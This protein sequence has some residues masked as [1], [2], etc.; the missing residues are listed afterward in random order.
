MATTF[1]IHGTRLGKQT[2]IS[3]TEGVGFDDPTDAT[4]YLLQEASQVCATPLGPC[5]PASEAE[6]VAAWLTALTALDTVT[7]LDDPDGVGR[8]LEALTEI[9]PDAVS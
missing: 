4:G 2:S 7:G 5:F 1:T 8:Q 6:P 3:W 9:P